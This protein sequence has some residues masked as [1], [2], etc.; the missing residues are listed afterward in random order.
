M[1]EHPQRSGKA[2][3][4]EALD[5]VDVAVRSCRRVGARAFDRLQF[6][7]FCL[8]VRVNPAT[9]EWVDEINARIERGDDFGGSTSTD[10]FKLRA[11]EER[12]RAV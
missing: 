7:L 5:A 12:L 9:R 4:S 3:V 1:N 2:Y 8:R 10:D 11:E 6:S